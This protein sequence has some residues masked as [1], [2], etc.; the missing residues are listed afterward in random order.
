[1]PGPRPGVARRMTPRSWS[2]PTRVPRRWS[3]RKGGLAPPPDPEA[4]AWE[5]APRTRAVERCAR[6]GDPESG[7]GRPGPDRPR[8][9]GAAGREQSERPHGRDGE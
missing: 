9:R 3:G 5:S 8:R 2:R 7:P 4:P 1:M 6:A